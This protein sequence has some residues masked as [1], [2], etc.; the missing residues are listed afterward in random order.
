MAEMTFPPLRVPRPFIGPSSPRQPTQPVG[1]RTGGLATTARHAYLL[2]VRLPCA[3]GVCAGESWT[4][5]GDIP[6]FPV[7]V[8]DRRGPRLYPPC[9]QP[10]L[11]ASYST[12]VG[13]GRCVPEGA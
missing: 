7:A 11:W 10:S 13:T 9:L 2:L 8:L 5:N 1:I 4:G 6:R 3:A 12:V